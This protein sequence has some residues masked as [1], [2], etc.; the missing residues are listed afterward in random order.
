MQ[1]LFSLLWTGF[2]YMKYKLLFCQQNFTFVNLNSIFTSSRSPHM[3]ILTQVDRRMEIINCTFI[4]VLQ[5]HFKNLIMYLKC[6]NLIQ[7]SHN[8][9]E[10]HPPGVSCLVTMLLIS[11]HSFSQDVSILYTCHSNCTSTTLTLSVPDP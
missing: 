11:R 10:L 5:T 2:Q 7:S 8:K 4:C 1:T 9:V 6:N 3:Q